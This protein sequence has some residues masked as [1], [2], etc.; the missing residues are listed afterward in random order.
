M[1]FSKQVNR[2]VSAPYNT[3]ADKIKSYIK[4]LLSAAKNTIGLVEV[5]FV[6]VQKQ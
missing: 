3:G 1:H 5:S 4:S 6:S 2:H